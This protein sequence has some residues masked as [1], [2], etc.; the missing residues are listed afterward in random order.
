M[1]REHAVHP[2]ALSVDALRYLAIH[3]GLQP[4]ESASPGKLK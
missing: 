4:V 3:S 2:Q 1:T